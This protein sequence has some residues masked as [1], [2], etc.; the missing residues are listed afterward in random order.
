MKR[1][2]EH[3]AL[4]SVSVRY[5]PIRKNQRRP[6]SLDVETAAKMAAAVAREMRERAEEEGKVLH[7]GEQEEYVALVEKKGKKG[8]KW[9]DKLVYCEEDLSRVSHSHSQTPGRS[10]LTSKVSSSLSPFILS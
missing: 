4:Y 3:N 9:D 2:T 1:N 8:I 6:S 10:I 5:Q 7:P